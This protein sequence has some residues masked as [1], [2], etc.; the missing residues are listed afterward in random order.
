MSLAEALPISIPWRGLDPFKAQ[1]LEASFNTATVHL[2]GLVSQ[3]LEGLPVGGLELRR[4]AMRKQ[5]SGK[6][7]PCH[8][9][10]CPA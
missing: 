9:R 8:S 6:L 10:G 7:N 3:E 4:Q 2:E 1:R 5:L